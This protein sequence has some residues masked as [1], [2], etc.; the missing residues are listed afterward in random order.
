MKMQELQAL[1]EARPF[2][3]FAIRV[4]ENR[5]LRVEHPEF[6]ALSPTGDVAIVFRPEGGVSIVDVEL[7][8]E[9]E[10]VVVP[11]APAQSPS[12]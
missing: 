4:G 11:D 8:S 2:R 3:P 9:L 6:L 12:S 5:L 7:V 1:H 10:V